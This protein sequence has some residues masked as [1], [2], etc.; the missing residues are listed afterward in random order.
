[1]I[2]EKAI[3]A[4]QEALGAFLKVDEVELP[5]EALRLAGELENAEK[6]LSKEDLDWLGNYWGL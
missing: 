4:Y 6:R 3:K 1:M 5:D 2:N